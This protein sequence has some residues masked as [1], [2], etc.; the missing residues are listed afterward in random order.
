M[1]YNIPNPPNPSSNNQVGTFDPP[2]SAPTPPPSSPGTFDPHSG[3]PIP[4]PPGAFAPP[5]KSYK[6]VAVASLVLGIVALTVPVP[7]LD[8]I[9]GI[10]GIILAAVAM[11][12]KAGGMAIAGLV[13][14]ILGTFAA[15][16]FT[17]GVFT[18]GW[19]GA[20]DVFTRLI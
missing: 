13:V 17:I 7:V 20:F 9:A 14:S 4:P 5:Q 16:S 15:I 8:I 12:N 2:P 19:E 3:A 6:G 18:Y 11:K 1:D 10:V